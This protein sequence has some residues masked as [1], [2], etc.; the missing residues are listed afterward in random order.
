M[1][2]ELV[3]T[4]ETGLIEV[5]RRHLPNKWGYAGD[6]RFYTSGAMRVLF[7][8]AALDSEFC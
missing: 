1:G 2:L 5:R 3:L 4:G 6:W 7:Q 8:R